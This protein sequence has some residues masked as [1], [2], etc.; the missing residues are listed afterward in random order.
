MVR[1]SS[2]IHPALGFSK[3]SQLLRL[4]L[5]TGKDEKK[6]RRK[7]V[8][9]IVQCSGNRRE[10]QTPGRGGGGLGGRGGDMFRVFS[11]ELKYVEQKGKLIELVPF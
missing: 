9:A 10:D 2:R 4:S 11:Y 6:F 8:A 3:V 7:K 5:S 1:N